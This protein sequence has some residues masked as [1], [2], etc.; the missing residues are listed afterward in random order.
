M[1]TQQHRI[2]A[3]QAPHTLYFPMTKSN[4][5]TATQ[6]HSHTSLT[7]PPHV[8][9]CVAVV[10]SMKRCTVLYT[11]KVSVQLFTDITTATHLINGLNRQPKNLVFT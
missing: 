1:G 5:Y 4:G 2:T 8:V 11:E 7:S 9:K 6:D 3:T 10:V